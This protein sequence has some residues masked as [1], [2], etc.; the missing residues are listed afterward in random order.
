MHKRMAAIKAETGLSLFVFLRKDA[1]CLFCALLRISAVYWSTPELVWLDIHIRADPC[2]G[3]R[4]KC[5]V[6]DPDQDKTL[7]S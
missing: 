4:D 1:I 7:N 3:P 2:T 5:P 6:K